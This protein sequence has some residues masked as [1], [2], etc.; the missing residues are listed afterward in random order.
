MPP[1]L[2]NWNCNLSTWLIR[3]SNTDTALHRDVLQLFVERA[4]EKKK[5]IFI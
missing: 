5:I 1:Q 2:F 3:D 4:R